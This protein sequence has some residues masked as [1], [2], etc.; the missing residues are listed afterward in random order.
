MPWWRMGY[1][2]LLPVLLLPLLF[3]A[4]A[5]EA[6]ASLEVRAQ[7]YP[8]G[9]SVEIE[10]ANLNASIYEGLRAHAEVFNETT[11]PMAVVEHLREGGLEEVAFLQPSIVFNDTERTV[12]MSFVLVGRDLMSFR[13]NTTSM[14]RIYEVNASWRKT[15]IDVVCEEGRLISLNFSSYFGAPLRDW[16]V[17]ELDLGGGDVRSALLLNS[18][19]ETL[20]DPLCYLILPRGAKLLEAREDTVVFEMPK[21][22]LDA[23]MASA[24]WPLLVVMAVVGLAISYRK[25]SIRLVKPSR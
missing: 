15:D 10:L 25:T 7:I 21:D 22:P 2:F 18:T 11:V 16:E 19:A 12:R 14:T 6:S 8:D 17:V 4:M 5:E 9:V 3:L 23:F 13:F 20:F 24:I 1:R